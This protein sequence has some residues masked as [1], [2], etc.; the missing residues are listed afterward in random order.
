VP[1]EPGAEEYADS[2]KYQLRQWQLNPARVPAHIFD[3]RK[4]VWSEDDFDYFL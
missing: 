1:R 3:A 2:E 4:R